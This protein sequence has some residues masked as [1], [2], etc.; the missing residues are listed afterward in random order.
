MLNT[1]EQIR[2]ALSS[3]YPIIL[4]VSPEEDRQEAIL[5]RFG[6]A[7]KPHELPVHVWNCVD[8]FIEGESDKH[9]DPMEGL[10]WIAN[11]APR[12]LYLLKDFDGVLM[13]DRRLRRRL[14][15]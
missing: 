3:A 5:R 9:T 14:R 2:T 15:S 11:S 8:G 6:S 1:T 10:A 4:L 7:A 12:G 13:E